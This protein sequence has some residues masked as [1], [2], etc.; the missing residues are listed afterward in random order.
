MSHYLFDQ[1]AFVRAA[2]L[3]TLEGISEE[4]ADVVPEGFRNGI[5][6][7]AG[8][9]AVVLERFAFQ[10]IGLPQRLPAGYKELF[11]YG[12][13]P[14]NWPEGTVP[15]TLPELRET[16]STQLG[17]IQEALGHRLPEAIV[18]P[19]TTSTGI[20]LASPEQFLSFNLYHEGMHQ[21]VIKQY[22]KLI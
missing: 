2:T 10:Y 1:L 11:E 9:V 8:H 7:N 4:A 5:R 14:L 22:K 18:P 3:R 15:P 19:Y 12:T 16:L 17:R 21:S 13:T 6:W 20:T